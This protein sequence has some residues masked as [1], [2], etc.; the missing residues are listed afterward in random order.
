MA[1]RNVFLEK[2]LARKLKVGLQMEVLFA[3]REHTRKVKHAEWSIP[4]SHELLINKT[5]DQ[6]KGMNRIWFECIVLGS[7]QGTM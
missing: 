2:K 4:D 3:A 5:A 1:K 7:K 6:V